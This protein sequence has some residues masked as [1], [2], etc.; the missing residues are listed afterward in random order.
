[1][2]SSEAKYCAMATTT[3]E[4]RWFCY[5]FSE[6]AIPL[7]H[8]SLFYDNVSAIHMAKNPVFHARARHIGIDYHF[9]HELVAR[10]ALCLR[11]VSTDDL[12]ADL[13]TKGLPKPH[14]QS[15]RTKLQLSFGRL[16]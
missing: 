4:L 8:P 6:L 1:M 13:F 16:T 11:C 15:M 2:L 12:L 3:V 14:F 7:P 10:G 5:L 9:I